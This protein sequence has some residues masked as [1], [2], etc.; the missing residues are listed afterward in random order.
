MT[1]CLKH[2]VNILKGDNLKQQLKSPKN[3]VELIEV[4]VQKFSDSPLFGTK[5]QA[6]NT[7]GL[8]TNKLEKE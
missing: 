4:S 1:G 5:I 3:L 6:V 7:N 8:P 2:P